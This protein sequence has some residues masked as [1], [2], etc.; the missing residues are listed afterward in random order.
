MR[1]PPR[2]QRR[3]HRFYC[4][5]AVPKDLRSVVGRTEIIRPLRT[6]DYA[7]ALR[8]LPLVSAEVDAELAA[9]RRKLRRE[10]AAALSEHEAKQVVLTWLW[11]SERQADAAEPPEDL[12]EAVAEADVDV[13]TLRDPGDPGVMAAAQQV[14][15]ALLGESSV[16]LDKAG[17]DYH[18]FCEL[19]RRS[20]LERARRAR[21]RLEGDYGVT[22]DPAFRAAA[23]GAPEPPR[24]E[25][26]G[27]TLRE[28]CDAYMADPARAGVTAKTR[29]DYE[30]TFRLLREVLGEDKVVRAISRADC[31][32]VRDLLARLPAHASKRWPGVPL[33]RVAETGAEEG[34]SPMAPRTANA[35][36]YKL[37]ALLRWA[38]RE[39]FADRNPA[40]GLRVAEPEVHASEARRPFSTRQLRRMFDAPLYRGC[41]DDQQHYAEPGP[42]VVRRWRFWLLPVGLFAGLRLNEACSLRVADL[43]R[44]DGVWCFVVRPDREEG[45]RLKSRSASRVVPVHPALVGMGLLCYAD[46]VRAGGDRMLFP[47]LEPDRRGYR[48]DRAQRWFGRFMEKA[49]AKEPRTSFHSSRH[50]F[51]DQLREVGAPRDVVL[52]L[53][54]WAGGGGTDDA[55]G[56]GLRAGTLHQWISKIEYEGLDLSHLYQS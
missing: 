56:G 24:P 2:L 15:D 7:E 10:P 13:A 12:R 26:R 5:V 49:G 11:R 44:R 52:A 54:G 33:A 14:A 29:L 53:G 50:C 28:L 16:A 38:E 27:I 31:R 37:S 48:A 19:V 47:E 41:V 42:N 6:G 1:R 32:A 21:A 45:R 39:E 17:R 8:R 25:P 55:Y 23:P 51:R 43:E 18:R 30:F 34:V 4:R 20:L 46:E 35:Y 40:V 22:F 3:G 36:L 9:A